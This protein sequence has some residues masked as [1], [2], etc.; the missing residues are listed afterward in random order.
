MPLLDLILNIAA[1][2]LWISWRAVPFDPF[3]RTRPATLT[4]TLRRANPAQT[5]RWHFLAA[6]GILLVVRALFYWWIGAA[7]DW[8]PGLKLGAISVSFRSDFL[9]RML[10]FSIAGF[11]ETLIVFYLWLILL[12]VSNP[13]F[14]EN[15]P[16]HRFLRI[17]LGPLH[18]WPWLL[19]VLFPMLCA[20]ALW[21]LL[22][23][24]LS[25]WGIVPPAQ[26][27]IHRLEQAAILGLGVYPACKYLIGTVLA[28]HLLSTY[29]HLGNHPVWDFIS[30]TARALISPFKWLPLR[31]GKADFAP[32]VGIAVTFVAAELAQRGLTRLFARL[33]L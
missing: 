19:K 8:A 13:R 32:V 14:L 4:G 30:T 16:C 27:L 23:P 25:M 26:T 11:M 3:S 18:G 12:S 24:L 6:L 28:L 22:A 31:F 10:V 7:L 1:L 2:L 15:N 5:K 9:W 21:L 17:Q 29:V 33:P 20:M